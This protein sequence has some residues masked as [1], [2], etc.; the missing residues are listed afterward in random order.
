MAEKRHDDGID[1][2]LLD[3]LIAA[4]GARSALE[5]ESLAVELKKAL[6]EHSPVR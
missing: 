1:R 6:A 4:C 2:D 5:F 3:E